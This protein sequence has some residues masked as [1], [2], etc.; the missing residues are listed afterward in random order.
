MVQIDKIKFKKEKQNEYLIIDKCKLREINLYI[1]F[2]SGKETFVEIKL[3]AE[4]KSVGITYDICNENGDPILFKFN[5][6]VSK[7]IPI[8]NIPNCDNLAIRVTFG[9]NCNVSEIGN[10]R[11]ST[12][13]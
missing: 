10:L 4:S 11:L 1:Q 9:G 7:I 3:I 13:R 2:I 12:K 8:N 5:T 6:D